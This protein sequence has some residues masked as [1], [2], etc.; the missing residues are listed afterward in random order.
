MEILLKNILSRLE[1]FVSY[2]PENLKPKNFIQDQSNSNLSIS[3][4]SE[5]ESGSKNSS[6]SSYNASSASSS[7]LKKQLNSI[8]LVP[9]NFTMVVFDVKGFRSSFFSKEGT[10]LEM[11]K[12]DIKK[13]VGEMNSFVEQVI[14]IVENKNATLESLEESK[15]IVC[16]NTLKKCVQHEL[17]AVS[18]AFLCKKKI[19]TSFSYRISISSE[20]NYL[21]NLGTNKFKRFVRL[22]GINPILSGMSI[23]ETPYKKD[24]PN[25]ILLDGNTQKVVKFEYNSKQIGLIKFHQF[26][27]FTEVYKIT[28]KRK[29]KA[30]VEWI[31]SGIT[32]EEKNISEK[33]EWESIWN[34]IMEGNNEEAFAHLVSNFPDDEDA[35]FLRNKIKKQSAIT[36]V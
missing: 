31:Y 33:R 26:E 35:E 5:T 25:E 27:K 6:R 13:L 29:I 1:E 19:K 24:S 12:E 9:I 10:L 17:R 32:K 4:K 30:N 18:F 16:F 20:S 21:G 34:M 8:G 11:E 15:I 7:K 28:S 3:I 36:I 14:N 23:L 22:G 2:L